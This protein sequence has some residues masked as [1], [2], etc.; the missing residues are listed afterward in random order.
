MRAALH[1]RQIARPRLLTQL[2]GL[3][4]LHAWGLCGGAA[5]R[6][7]VVGACG[8]ILLERYAQD[9]THSH[10]STP[11]MATALGVADAGAIANGSISGTSSTERR[12]V[13]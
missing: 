12:E 11:P 7:P 5:S 13:E 1:R 3:S 8:P 9:L 4:C 2:T 6:Q 10:P